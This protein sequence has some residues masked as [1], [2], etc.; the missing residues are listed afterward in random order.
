A[1]WDGVLGMQYQNREL[2]TSGE[3]AFVPD[4]QAEVVSGFILEKL[5][6]DR[7]QFEM[8]GRFEHQLAGRQED[9]LAVTHNV[10]SLSGGTIWTFFDGYSLGGNLSH[11]Q[12]APA[13]EELFSN[14]PHLATNSFE[15]G[16]A[17]L[18]KEKSN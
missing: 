8:G 7:W 5:E 15:I 13:L 2:S 6:L 18:N 1:G 11:A 12:R 3:E 9:D 4:S 16:S 10:F 17:S 14:G